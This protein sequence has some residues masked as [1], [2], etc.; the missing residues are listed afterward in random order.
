MKCYVIA[1]LPYSNLCILLKAVHIFL[2]TWFVF[3]LMNKCYAC[4]YM[5][6]IVERQNGDALTLNI[7]AAPDIN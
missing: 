3:A 6:E 5:V 2:D 7:K 4:G 1:S